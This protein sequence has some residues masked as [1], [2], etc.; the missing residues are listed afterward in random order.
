MINYVPEPI[1]G[2]K[3]SKKARLEEGLVQEVEEN[4]N[5]ICD[6]VYPPI[7]AERLRQ[8]P[9]KEVPF[10]LIGGLLVFV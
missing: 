7:V 10:S 9:E 4:C 5:L 6:P 3:R 8:I 1:A 2:E